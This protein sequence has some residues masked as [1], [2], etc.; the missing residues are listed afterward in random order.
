[1]GFFFGLMAYLAAVAMIVVSAGA[2]S[3]L[4]DA[5]PSRLNLGERCKAHPATQRGCNA[6]DEDGGDF[7]D[8]AAQ[9]K[10]SGRRKPPG[11]PT[12]T[13]QNQ[14]PIYRALAVSLEP[15]DCVRVGRHPTRVAT[16]A[17]FWCLPRC[18]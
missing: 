15:G 2:G 17:H 1:M 5:P 11:E 16:C 8:V 9:G 3:V 4:A 13:G 10:A 12:G 18:C 7:L 6:V 14:A